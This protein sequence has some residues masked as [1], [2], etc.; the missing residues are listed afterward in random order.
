MRRVFTLLIV[1][2]FFILSPIPVNAHD[3][4]SIEMEY[5]YALQELTFII[6]HVVD[7]PTVH[8]I[9][10]V[11]IC[12]DGYVRYFCEYDQQTNCTTQMDTVDVYFEDGEQLSVI[13]FCN[14]GGSLRADMIVDMGSSTSKSSTTS[15]TPPVNLITS[16]SEFNTTPTNEY[17]KDSLRIIEIA[18][19]GI[20]C[21][22]TIIVF[23]A[24]YKKKKR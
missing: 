11:W 14:E 21:G 7:D 23:Y 1:F 15:T 13:A 9:D 16:T 6:T 10:L 24:F 2:M 3:P 19:L 18:T 4:E 22:I 12:K 5:D 17:T 20:F 8:Y